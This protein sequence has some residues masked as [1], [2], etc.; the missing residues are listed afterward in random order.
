M[1][2]FFLL[3]INFSV[4]FVRIPEL[5]VLSKRLAYPIEDSRR[6]TYDTLVESVEHLIP[7]LSVDVQIY[8][9]HLKSVK[10]YADCLLDA[11]CGTF[12][13]LLQFLC[14]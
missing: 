11:A 1:Y 3:I 9:K 8:L 14:E 2:I 4:D 7:T 10:T 12:E 13:Y 6:L 5:A